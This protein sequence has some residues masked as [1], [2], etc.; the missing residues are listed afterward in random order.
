MYRSGFITAFGPGSVY[1][2]EKGVARV[3]IPDVTGCTIISQNDTEEG[4]PS[5]VTQRTAALLQRY[6]LGERIEFI[7][8][9]VDY[10]CL[11]PFRRTVLTAA[12]RVYYGETCSYSQLARACGAPLAARAIGG[13]L[14]ANPVPV[15]I[16]CH[17]VVSYAG[18]LTGFSATGGTGAKM[19]ML[20]MEGVRFNGS[21]VV[22]NQLVM[23]REF[24]AL[25]KT[26]DA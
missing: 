22:V 14:A 12:R 18:R 23:H 20:Q 11:T 4:T 6:F 21:Q 19:F 17:R 26:S 13:A 24:V 5:P 16:P 9:P 25:K 7:D 10:G 2:T 15:V 8:I 3:F 1:A